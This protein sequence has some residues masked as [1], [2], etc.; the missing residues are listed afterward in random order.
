[1]ERWRSEHHSQRR[2]VREKRI[3]SKQV[4]DEREHWVVLI[5]LL[6]LLLLLLMMTMMTMQ[7]DGVLYC[8]FFFLFFSSLLCRGPYM[9]PLLRRRRGVLD[10]GKKTSRRDETLLHFIYILA[11]W[12]TS[13]CQASI[14]IYRVFRLYLAFF[15]VIID[16]GFFFLSFICALQISLCV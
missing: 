6:L 12:P 2:S 1:M 15:F 10:L 3:L 16:I 8:S 13:A 14:F 4:Y 7:S 11:S 9:A 5:V